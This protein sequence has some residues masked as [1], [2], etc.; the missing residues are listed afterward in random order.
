MAGVSAQ[1]HLDRIVEDQLLH[2]H[3]FFF[4]WKK[5]YHFCTQPFKDFMTSIIIGTKVL[6]N[7]QANKGFQIL[8]DSL[9]INVL[10]KQSCIFVLLTADTRQHCPMIQQNIE[11]N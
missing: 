1:Y 2:S 8:G 11:Q 10:L 9:R 3:I 6:S 5:K 7:G 4:N